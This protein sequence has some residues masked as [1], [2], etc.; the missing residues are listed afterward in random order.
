[1]TL[2]E[3]KARLTAELETANARLAELESAVTAPAEA[4]Q[5]GAELAK[6]AK[7]LEVS[8]PGYANTGETPADTAIRMLD[9][10]N[11]TAPA[12]VDPA[13]GQPMTSRAADDAGE[14][15]YADVVIPDG[16][17]HD[18]TL[19]ALAEELHLDAKQLLALNIVTL[20]NEAHARGLA[21]SDGGRILFPGTTLR[22]PVEPAAA[23]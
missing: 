19:T 21:D 17:D 20:D 23:P 2:T 7:F 16:L 22:V 10:A 12:G 15:T 4:G 18:I 1:M 3:D 6:L 8:Y 14:I 13:S 9:R 5:G 11:A